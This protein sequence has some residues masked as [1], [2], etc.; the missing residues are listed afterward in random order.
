MPLSLRLFARTASGTSFVGE[1]V[2][3]GERV[4]VGRSKQCTLSLDDPEMRM[5][6]VHA[7]LLKTAGGY[8]LKVTSK[9]A[10]V[11]VNGQPYASGSE[12]KVRVGDVL[13]LAD[14]ELAI[15][16]TGESEAKPDATREP[17]TQSAAPD[18]G[19]GPGDGQ[20]KWLAI[21]AAAGAG[22]LALVLLWPMLDGLVPDNEVR[23]NAEQ[24]IASLEGQA[25]GLI[26][27]LESD[28]REFKEAVADSNREIERIEG[29]LRAAQSGQA[30][31]PLEAEL[32]EARNTARLNSDLDARVRD[33]VEG[34]RGLP[35]AE[36]DLG[37]AAVAAKGKDNK[38]AIRLLE[39]A[40]SSL[41]QIRSGIAAD[42]KTAQ[43][44]RER[45][46]VALRAQSQPGA[47]AVSSAA[48]VRKSDPL[49]VYAVCVT[50]AY[51]ELRVRHPRPAEA[52]AHSRL[53]CGSFRSKLEES[54]R[55]K[56]GAE[57][58]KVLLAI[59]V[60]L[61]RSLRAASK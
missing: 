20:T 48:P 30:R 16:G 32:R 25:R 1:R 7:E 21:G 47:P 54:L 10:P 57:T 18:T 11:L 39:G 59:D 26:K 42:R 38:E 55:R 8:L 49:T 43:A 35:K 61:L 50:A 56:A 36:G 34:S 15:V 6:R 22:V 14:Y 45:G 46:Q 12:V 5:S 29:L 28:R 53:A 4:T 9:N 51:A 33:E 27:L 19:L 23:K 58:P 13:T 31:A 17:S 24:E 52:V 44:E 60:Q 37:A 41:T 40:V 3:E 2:L